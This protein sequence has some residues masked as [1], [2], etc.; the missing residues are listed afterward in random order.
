MKSATFQALK[1]SAGEGKHSTPGLPR[2]VF[3]W[4]S[5]LLVAAVCLKFSFAAD[6]EK[7]EVPKSPLTP[8][9]SLQQTVVHPDFE[10]Q[11]V[12]SEPNIINPVA[13][14]FDETGVLWK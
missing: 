8:E 5:L 11:V 3:R 12:A 4:G 6:P 2:L 1:Q 10:M 14:A 13:V 7:K 9:E